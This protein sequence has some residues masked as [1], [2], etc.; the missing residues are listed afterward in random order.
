M[1]IE[2]LMNY[3]A[4][5]WKGKVRVD[6]KTKDDFTTIEFETDAKG[7]YSVVGQENVNSLLFAKKYDLKLLN[8]ILDIGPFAEGM[9]IINTRPLTEKEKDL[10]DQGW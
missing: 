7:G 2:E 6:I 10:G 3:V 9:L 4:K 8:A 1:K 5:A